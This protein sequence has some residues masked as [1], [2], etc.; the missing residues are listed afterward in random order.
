MNFYRHHWYYVGAIVFIA[1]SFFMG[2][3][4]KAFDDVHVTMIYSFMALLVHQFEEYALPG[5]FPA[6]FNVA[7]LGEKTVPERFP[8]NA[9][10]CLV[11][12]V[13]LAY[14]LYLAGIYWADVIWLGIAVVIFGML[15]L[16]VHGIVINVKLK[17]LYNPGLVSVIC[18]FCPIGIYYFSLIDVAHLASTGDF[19]IGSVVA[20]LAAFVTVILPLR[21]MSSKRSRFPFSEA[22]MSGF[23]KTKVRAIRQS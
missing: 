23:G 17:S 12:N 8:L 16:L 7:V 9:N 18:L 14:P 2:F 21:L 15:Q 10:Q 20:L 6:I 4:G 19:I 5:G 3:F 11:T 13:F 22:E 1:L